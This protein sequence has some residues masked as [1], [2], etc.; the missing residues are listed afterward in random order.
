MQETISVQAHG[1]VGNGKVL[2]TKAF[3]AAIDEAGENGKVV[4][5]PGQ[6]LV[7]SIFLKSNMEF[8]LQEGAVLLGSKDCKDYPLV[9]SRV[10]G[11]EM[12]WPA[13]IINVFD[14]SNVRITGKG[15]IDGQGEYWWNKYWGADGHG[16][17]RKIY[18]SK[19]L[20]WVADYEIQRPRMILVF[21]SESVELQDFTAK[22]SGFWTVQITYS[23]KI[24]IH[25]IV[26]KDNL[27]PSTDGIDIDSSRQILIENCVISC[28]DDD[29]AIKSGRDADGLRVNRI[30][31]D[32]EI[33]D[34]T[35]L[36]GAGITL[37]SEVA[38][39]I[40]NIR[41]H[42][43]LFQNTDCGFRIKSSR[44]R[45]GFIEKIFVENLKM[46]NVQFPFSWLLDWFPEYNKITF[47][48]NESSREPIPEYWQR[49]AEK[50]PIEKQGTKVKD[51]YICNVVSDVEESY[52]K[53]SRAF[54]IQ[55]LDDKPME[56]ILFDKVKINAGEFGN[57]IAVKNFQLKEV[58]VSAEHT[59][60]PG[61]DIYDHR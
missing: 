38:G 22:K 56:N 23:S 53:S 7:G 48:A 36:S 31:E 60:C 6:Y 5:E 37:G 3:Q 17:L 47:F 27:G 28:N 39:G 29:I 32:V 8:H 33:R 42:N 51:I 14:K 43:I 34:C 46:I 18:D 24:H 41:I 20:R 58:Y 57:I 16:G 44:F 59:N 11:I 25:D 2:D 19:N 52:D 45:G 35:I 30:C 49:I 15:I 13:A 26:I 10:A 40:R 50:V 1:A 9:F 12:D 54:D 55:G 4:V 61:N 21:N